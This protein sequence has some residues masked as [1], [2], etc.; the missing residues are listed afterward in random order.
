M[1]NARRFVLNIQNKNNNNYGMLYILSSSWKTKKNVNKR[2]IY[3][4][5]NVNI[6]RNFSGVAKKYNELL[7]DKKLKRDEA[8]AFAIENLEKLSFK[9][10][11]FEHEKVLYENV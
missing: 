8:Q 3:I 6:C 5:N 1:N 2:N 4:R 9:L 10:C 7:R 11:K